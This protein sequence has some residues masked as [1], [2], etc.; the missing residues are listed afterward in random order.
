MADEIIGDQLSPQSTPSAEGSE[1]VQ[2]DDQVQV[3]NEEQTTQPEASSENQ[4]N[5]EKSSDGTGE[6]SGQ[7]AKPS[8]VERRIH[9]LLSKVKEV[10]NTPASEKPAN[11]E[12]SLFTE[13][14]KQDLEQ[15]IIDP[16]TLIK[17]VQST[18]QSEVQKAIQ[19]D[20]ITQ[21]YQ[22]AVTEHAQDLES[23]K[24][25]DPD[26][27]AEAVAE[28]EALNYQTNPFTGEREF[29]PAV[30]LSEIVAKIENRAQKIATKMAEKIAEGN[31]KH[32]QDV[33]SSQAV[34]SNG[35]VGSTQSVSPDT[36][37]FSAFEKAYSSK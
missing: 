14:E 3:D 20:R 23:V 21:Q 13:Q 16:E 25:I 15:G 36:T 29:V 26:L 7:D 24:D 12:E 5:G 31:L 35:A 27:E 1:E 28:Y 8:R 4:E 22:S 9:D 32:L 30:K 2:V 18:V 6:Q 33:S 34:P 10:G 37:D 17:R 19:I 11:S